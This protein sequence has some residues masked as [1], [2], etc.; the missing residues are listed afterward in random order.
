MWL[1]PLLL[2][3]KPLLQSRPQLLVHLVEG[4]DTVV[5]EESAIANPVSAKLMTLAASG[6][7]IVPLSHVGLP[8]DSGATLC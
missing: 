1:Q 5:A 6:A 4:G 8:L 2:V 3:L 7:V